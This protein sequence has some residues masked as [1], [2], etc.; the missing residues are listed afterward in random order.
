M[1]E[2]R[3]LFRWRLL[4]SGKSGRLDSVWRWLEVSAVPPTLELIVH[5]TQLNSIFAI[6]QL[7]LQITRLIAFCGVEHV[8]PYILS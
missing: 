2:A 3:L 5:N 1:A 8:L 4:L 7:K 6:L